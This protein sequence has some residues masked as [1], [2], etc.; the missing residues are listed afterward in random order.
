[1]FV[2]LALTLAFAN[3][4]MAATV[5]HSHEHEGFHPVHIVLDGDHDRDAHAAD[6]EHPEI[7]PDAGTPAPEHSETGFHSHSTPQFGPADASV[8]IAVHL[9]TDRAAPIE[10]ESHFQNHRDRP[11]FKPPRFSL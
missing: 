2:A 4:G 7:D 3:Y 9:T 1:M 8:L 11:P 6:H 5:V 10:P